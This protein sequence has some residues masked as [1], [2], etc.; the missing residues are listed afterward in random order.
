[1]W[2]KY[3]HSVHVHAS[4]CTIPVLLQGLGDLTGSRLS[5]L[6]SSDHT[7][8]FLPPRCCTGSV[9]GQKNSG[10]S[11]HIQGRLEAPAM[12]Q[13]TMG[14][15]VQVRFSWA[16]TFSILICQMVQ[17][18]HLQRSTGLRKDCFMLM[19]KILMSV[20][21]THNLYKLRRKV[22]I[23]HREHCIT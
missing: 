23:G 1:M 12:C 6:Y 9:A 22:G 14:G 10:V 2:T 11:A 4:F 5:G 3:V 13:E 8:F 15:P 7:K 21:K 18:T 20:F 16:G 17:S 19:H